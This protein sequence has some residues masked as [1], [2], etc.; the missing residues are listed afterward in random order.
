M[1]AFSVGFSRPSVRG[2]TLRLGPG[3]IVAAATIL[4]PAPA[5][6]CSICRC[7][8]PTFNALGKEGYVAQG[9]RLA[10]DSERFDKEEGPPEEEAEAQVE[11]RVTALASYGF[12]DRF[13]LY[14]R[15]P[16]SFRRFS[17]I[18]EGVTTEQFETRGLSDPEVYGQVRL[19]GSPLAGGVGRRTSLTL[20]GGVKMPFGQNDYRRDGER[21]DE[22]AQPGTGSWD[23]FG[24]VG[25]L[26][27]VDKRSALFVSSQYRHTGTNDFGYRYG[28]ILLANAAYERKLNARIDGVLELN[29]RHAGQDQDGAEAAPNTG[30]S[31]LYVTPRVLLDLGR[32]VVLRAAVQVPVAR[33]LNGAQKER[34]V[35]NA[36]L[37]FLV[38][39]R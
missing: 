39:S 33:D 21:V 16:Y 1:S 38:G 17:E 11:N 8:D 37:S 26:H 27:L 4:V 19:W 12:S 31:I 32:G 25:V 35:V 22:H 5:R 15:V 2:K 13:T 29:Y 36:G 3:L 9:W 20:L 23:A 30:G 7:G 6:A 24:G 10:L 34:V 14:A 18:Q 28:R